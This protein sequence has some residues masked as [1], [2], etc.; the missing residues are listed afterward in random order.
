[1]HIMAAPLHLPSDTSVP[2]ITVRHTSVHK[3]FDNPTAVPAPA[4][5][6]S[7]VA[8]LDVGDATLLF[9]S[10]Q[11]AVDDDNNIV[12][13][14]DLTAQSERVF[15]I[16]GAIL[17]AHGASFDDVVNVRTF[18]TDISRVQEYGAVRAKY[19]TGQPPTSTTVETP[20]LFKPEALLEV[21][22]VAAISRPT[23]DATGR[24][25]L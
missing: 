7:H 23:R 18:L 9:L 8:R 10:G 2:P 17:A 4:G 6:Y 11:V 14:G 20:R 21:E 3:L 16:I 13:P 19:I 5:H 22:V 12:A 25:P 24:R 1:M 15:E